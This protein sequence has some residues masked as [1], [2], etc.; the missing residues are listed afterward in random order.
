MRAWCAYLDNKATHEDSLAEN[1]FISQCVICDDNPGCTALATVVKEVKKPGD[2]DSG[3]PGRLNWSVKVREVRSI[4]HWV[5]Q[6]GFLSATGHSIA[7]SSCPP[8][9]RSE[10]RVIVG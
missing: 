8:L 1:L 4:R 3:G 7:W 10:V 9:I 2:A 6:L 5:G